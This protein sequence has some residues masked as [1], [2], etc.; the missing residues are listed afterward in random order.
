MQSHIITHKIKPVLRL[1]LDFK[2]HSFHDSLIKSVVE[3]SKLNEFIL[4]IDWLKDWE[5]NKFI[6]ANLVFENVL[7]YEVHEIPFEGNPTILDIYESGSR[8]DYGI[9]RLQ[10]KI[11]TNAGYRT[12]YCTDAKIIE[13]DENAT[14][15]K[16]QLDAWVDGNSICLIAKTSLGDP[17]DLN[18]NEIKEFILKLNKCLQ[19]MS[20]DI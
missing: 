14:K 6:E 12:L 3:N 8:I 20:R 19:I 7:N 15:F 10:I 2:E 11:E 18:E 16:E 17:L 4:C 5:N 13:N 1:Q 9:K